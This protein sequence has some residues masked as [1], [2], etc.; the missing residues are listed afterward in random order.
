MSS[1]DEQL[2]TMLEKL[3]IL[4]RTAP[5]EIVE[6]DDGISFKNN[7]NQEIAKIYIAGTELPGTE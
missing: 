2:L 3:E 1:L 5:V 6:C 4:E 7:F